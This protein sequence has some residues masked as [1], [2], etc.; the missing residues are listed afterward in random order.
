MW[1]FFAFLLLPAQLPPNCEYHL[2]QTLVVTRFAKGATSTSSA[3]SEQTLPWRRWCGCMKV[4]HCTARSRV[5]WTPLMP[6]AVPSSWPISHWSFRRCIETTEGGTSVLH[7]TTKEKQSR[8]HW[9]SKL[10]VSIALF[11]IDFQIKLCRN[12][13]LVM[14]SLIK[15]WCWQT[16]TNFNWFKENKVNVATHFILPCF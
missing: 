7:S 9:C 3:V 6:L 13:V 2:A 12:I 11:L 14:L 5:M 10:T 1:L 16:L 15:G 8:S 4:A